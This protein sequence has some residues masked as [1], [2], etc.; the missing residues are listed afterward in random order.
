M[1][2]LVFLG[3]TCNGSTWREEIIPKLNI[4]YF[5]P[6]VDDWNEEARELEEKTKNEADYNLFVITPKMVGVFSIAEVVD[7]SN[8][9]PEKTILCILEDDGFSVFNNSAYS[10]LLAVADLVEENG[11][12]VFYRLEDVVEYLNK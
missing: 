11:A 1:N 5:D 4:M 6:V 8:K 12:E 9:C 3:G 10:S 7:C 2:K